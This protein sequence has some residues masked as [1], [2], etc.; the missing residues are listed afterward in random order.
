M[1][2]IELKSGYYMFGNKGTVWS[3]TAHIAKS[4]SSVTLCG[5]P[6]LSSNWAQIMKV[7]DLGCPGCIAKYQ[8]ANQ[9]SYGDESPEEYARMLQEVGL[10]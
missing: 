1:K 7:Q 10:N 2:K 3:N 9:P 4:G 6:M 8:S 5:T